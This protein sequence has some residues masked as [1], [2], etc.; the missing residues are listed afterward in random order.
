MTDLEKLEAAEKIIDRSL[1]K[2]SDNALGYYTII[3]KNGKPLSRD[4]LRVLDRI[5]DKE[6]TINEILF[7][8]ENQIPK[9][10]DN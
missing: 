10:N 4:D 9:K 1:I 2:F 6:M 5:A 3:D 7:N 8:I